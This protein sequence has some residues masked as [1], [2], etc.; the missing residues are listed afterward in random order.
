MRPSETASISCRFR[1]RI[2]KR[3]VA[4]RASRSSTI[5]LGAKAAGRASSHPFHERSDGDVVREMK[6]VFGR[7][8]YDVVCS[9]MGIT[10]YRDRAKP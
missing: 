5:G 6:D 10:T 8:G 1:A 7:V 9:L 4:A 2:Q 3:A